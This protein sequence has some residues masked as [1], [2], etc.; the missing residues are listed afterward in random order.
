LTSAF[1]Y[2][3]IRKI[4]TDSIEAKHIKDSRHATEAANHKNKK[5]EHFYKS[6]CQG[7]QSQVQAKLRQQRM[8]IVLPILNPS[9]IS[10]AES[11]SLS[12]VRQL[13]L[14]PSSGKLEI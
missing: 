1:S 8:K 3:S 12:L 10:Y 7:G 4:H 14:V 11:F 2:F 5:T 9:P 6:Y 13:P